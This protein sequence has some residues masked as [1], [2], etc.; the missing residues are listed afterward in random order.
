MTKKIFLD[1]P[2]ARI[3]SERALFNGNYKIH[4]RDIH[5]VFVTR[6][7]GNRRYYICGGIGLLLVGFIMSAAGSDSAGTVM[8]VGTAL[9]ILPFLIK[10]KYILRIKTGTGEVR[11]L[12]SSDKAGLEN[13]RDAVNE[14]INYEDD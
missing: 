12:I 2:T 13:I 6:K 11:P 14:A 5:A 8:L 9:I 10:R 7:A 1:T 3:D 4:I